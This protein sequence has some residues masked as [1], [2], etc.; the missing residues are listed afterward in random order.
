MQNLL[1]F[2]YIPIGDIPTRRKL[3][4][5]ERNMDI[6][7]AEAPRFQVK[8]YSRKLNGNKH[9]PHLNFP[10]QLICLYLSSLILRKICIFILR[11]RNRILA[12]SASVKLSSETKH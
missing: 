7:A 8:L 12:P 1:C 3:I 10:E 9:H 2:S 5:P 6:W 4:S 11:G